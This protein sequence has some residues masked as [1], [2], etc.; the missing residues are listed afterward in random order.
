ME[1]STIIPRKGQKVAVFDIDGTVF[2]W[3]LFLDL[4]E[5]FIEKGIFPENSREEYYK[6]YVEWLDRKG[7]Y[8][9]YLNK[10]VTIFEKNLK[11]VA[12]KDAEA[13]AKEIINEK[14]SRVYRYTR[15]LITK[16]KKEGYFLL[17]ISHSPFFI[18]NAFGK[19]AG[20][21]KV[22]GFFYELGPSDCFTGAALDRELITNKA[23]VLQR[24]VRKEDLSFEGS[25]GVGDT[26]SDVPM[27][28][29]VDTAIAFNPNHAL[30]THAKRC[31]WKIVVERKDVIYEI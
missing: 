30:Y 1:N 24:A 11:G 23:A 8:K 2:R 13:V 31:N 9:T 18:A 4:V 6:E 27:L 28:E 26:E 5:K 22:Y 10:V 3:S 17:A 12:F 15:D 7:E 14:K 20:F 29:L 21:D 19:E 16:L 25:V